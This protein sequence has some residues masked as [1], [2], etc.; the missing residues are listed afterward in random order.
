MF[1]CVR[2]PRCIDV[3]Q[4]GVVCVC[5]CVSLCLCVCVSVCLCVCVSVCLCVCVS[6]CLWVCVSLGPS[7]CVC[8]SV[9]V[10]F[11]LCLSVLL[12][13]N[14]VDWAMRRFAEKSQELFR[15]LVFHLPG[16]CPTQLSFV[17]DFISL[18]T[19]SS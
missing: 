6:V 8:V 10:C 4:C 19:K 2:V 18:N 1:V 13:V 15:C 12:F 7:A 14:V 16:P 3:C 11:C 9:S 5:V 17:C